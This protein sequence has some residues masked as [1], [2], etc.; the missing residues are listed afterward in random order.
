MKQIFGLI[1]L[2]LAVCTAMVGHTIHHSL[3]WSIVDF[4]FYPVAWAKWLI[5][6]QVNLTVIKATFSFFLT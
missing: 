5:C 1:W 3:F 2:I 4:I 6:H